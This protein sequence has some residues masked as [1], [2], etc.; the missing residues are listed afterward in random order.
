MAAAFVPIGAPPSS[1]P[2]QGL[3]AVVGGEGSEPALP[4][5][6]EGG[7]AFEPERCGPPD[8]P[9][10]GDCPEA[11]GVDP[12]DDP[13]TKDTGAGSPVVQY[14][15][16]TAWVGDKCSVLG[17]QGRDPVAR[18]R[19]LYTASESRI[20]EAELWS[21]TEAQLRAYPNNYLRNAASPNFENLTPGIGE[22]SPGAYALGELQAAIAAGQTGR[23][24]IHA[25]WPVVN[26]WFFLGALRREGAL[27]LDVF[28]NLIVAG[29]GYDG[30]APDGS[31]VPLDTTGATSWAYATGIVQTKRHQQTKVVPDTLN[32]A[33]TID[34]N[35][36]EWRVER[37]VA[38]WWDG[39][40]HAAINVDLCN[41]C[42]TGAG[43]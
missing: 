29:T 24:M 39:C 35:D 14:R 42:C 43:S 19:R 16:Y 18:A 22:A 38:A 37:L 11:G 41:T 5:R 7:F 1:P 32:E 9:T 15:P 23:G 17:R 28:D 21:G 20:M 30:S 8:V 4:E 12:R 26:L 6:W 31:P 36:E 33:I 13:G 10:W 27:I 2:R 3:L 40:V 34:V 25:T